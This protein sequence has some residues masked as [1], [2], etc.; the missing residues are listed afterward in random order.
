[1]RDLIKQILKEETNNPQTPYDIVMKSNVGDIIPESDVYQYVQKIHNNYDDFIDGNLGERIE[2]F[3]KY[4][5][6]LI[7]IDKIVTDEYYLDDDMMDDYVNEYKNNKSYPPIVLGY[8]DNRWGYDIIDGNHRANALKSIGVKKIKSLVGLN[9]YQKTIT[10]GR[11]KK[12]D[13][14]DIYRDDNLIVVAPLTHDA[15]KKYASEC[16]WCIN[17][18]KFEWENYH[19]GKI[20]VIIQRKPRKNNIGF[21]DQETSEEI[22]DFTHNGVRNEEEEDYFQKLTD[23]IYN[24]DTNIIYY[25][26]VSGTIYDKGDNLVTNFGYSIWDIPNMNGKII[27]KIKSALVN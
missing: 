14:I 25:E 19:Q 8:Y 13:R 20:A 11:V 15:L 9:D 7:D 27:E 6:A 17:S 10:E 16:A 12:S 18:D 1:M 4:Q 22:Y 23:S 21:T 24:F 26:P 2:R 3:P 5:V